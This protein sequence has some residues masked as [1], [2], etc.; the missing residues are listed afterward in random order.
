MA[1][2]WLFVGWRRNREALSDFCSQ[3]ITVNA[4]F[5][6][7]E[8]ARENTLCH[9]FTC[10]LSEST[11]KPFIQHL[12]KA[13]LKGW[14]ESTVYTEF[15]SRQPR[16]AVQGAMEKYTAQ[17]NPH[18]MDSSEAQYARA[19][20]TRQLTLSQSL[21]WDS[22]A[23][24]DWCIWIPAPTPLLP[25]PSSPT[26]CSLLRVSKPVIGTNTKAETTNC[27]QLTWT[28]TTTSLNAHCWKTQ[29]LQKKIDHAYCKA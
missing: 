2:F 15:W 10:Q 8:N 27:S 21:L 20:R 18:K 7:A 9:N 22:P 12:I 17:K 25:F 24:G 13:P 29:V 11:L 16:G 1:P 5:C 19:W 26:P 14:T 28:Q 3:S 23:L 4:Q 6:E